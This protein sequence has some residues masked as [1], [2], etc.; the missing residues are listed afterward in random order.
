[1]TLDGLSYSDSIVFRDWIV[2]DVFPLT[3]LR[4][5]GL[6]VWAARVRIGAKG[7][8]SSREIDLAKV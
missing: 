7:N 4:R 1:M 3:A 8:G 5:Q 6:R 2:V